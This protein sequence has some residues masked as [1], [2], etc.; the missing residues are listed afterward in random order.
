MYKTYRSVRHQRGNINLMQLFQKKPPAAN[1]NGP[2]PKTFKFDPMTGKP[3]QA[4]VDPNNPNPNSADAVDPNNPDGGSKK[5]PLDAFKNLW[6][7]DPNKS[8]GKPPAFNLDP[9]KLSE[10][11]KSLD[12]SSHVTPELAQKLQSGD[13]NTL[14][15]ALNTLGQSVYGT[16]FQHMPQ[17]TE[18]YVGARLEHDR[19]G[20]GHSV[21]STLT[22]QSLSKLAADNPVL[23][24]QLEMIGEELLKNHPDADPDWIAGQAQ[25]YFVSIAKSVS[26]DSFKGP[27]DSND[28]NKQQDGSFDFG[29]WMTNKPQPQSDPSK[30]NTQ[31]Q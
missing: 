15:E 22:K 2:D 1:P 17:L 12:F 8:D 11:T 30:T 21:K 27:N 5:N 24:K 7:N 16:V 23:Q 28:K 13:V 31:Q 18:S 29:A 3:I 25:E 20:L 26:P 10:L 4:N 14:K 9:T 19:K 6:S